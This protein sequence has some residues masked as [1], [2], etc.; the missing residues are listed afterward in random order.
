M[1]KNLLLVAIICMG[2]IFSACN[3]TININEADSGEDGA[4]A[5]QA[6]ENSEESSAENEN[7]PEAES[8][9]AES[10]TSEVVGSSEADASSTAETDSSS[11]ADVSST[12]ESDSSSETKPD[13]TSESQAQS[14]SQPETSSER[15][16]SIDFLRRDYNLGGT[17]DAV[18]VPIFT[19][20]SGES[21]VINRMNEYIENTVEIYTLDIEEE[22]TR[23]FDGNGGVSV[24]TYPF[25]SE[26]Y[27]QVVVRSHLY[28]RMGSSGVISSVTYD[29]E[30]NRYITLNDA[31]ILSGTS[32]KEIIDYTNSLLQPSGSEL[33]QYTSVH[34]FMINEEGAEE[35]IEFFVSATVFA[36]PAE[37]Q[38]LY[39]YIP[40]DPASGQ[41]ILTQLDTAMLFP[42]GEYDEL[43][44][45]LEADNY[46][47]MR[48]NSAVNNFI[49]Y[50]NRS[51]YGY[52][53]VGDVLIQGNMCIEILATPDNA[54]DEEMRFA[55]DI[56]D[57]LY[58]YVDVSGGE[59]IPKYHWNN[60]YPQ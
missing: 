4:S 54:A 57:N 42:Y 35:Y 49:S 9:T 30:N 56:W 18:E 48:A 43:S 3:N 25:T 21:E 55:I 40:H 58:K 29:I 12:A 5:S 36:E 32:E 6:S 51:G 13:S 33:G 27:L 34:G 53:A 16:V 41:P 50:E 47:L 59:D 7:A 28:A 23:M 1:K 15:N 45:P 38:F 8:S 19:M 44:E 60:Y 14:S 31:Y 17:N 39:S 20:E 11:K 46:F 10:P 24:M 37:T 22:N 2:L 26:K 52:S